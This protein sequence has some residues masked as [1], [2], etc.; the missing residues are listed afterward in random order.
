[1]IFITVSCGKK[2]FP[3]DNQFQMKSASDTRTSKPVILIM[4]DSLLPSAIQTGLEQDILPTFKFLME[5]GQYYNDFVSSFPTMSV[6]IDSTLLTGTYPDKHRV[7]GLLWYS[8]QDR[9]LINYGTTTKEIIRRGISPFLNQALIQLNGTHLS[10][11][12][13]T[14]YED[15][16]KQGLQSGSVNGIIHRGNTEHQLVFP[17]WLQSSASMPDAVTVKGPDFFTYG[18]FSNPL[19]GVIDLKDGMTQKMG[20]N[21]QFSAD[22][23]S[24]LIKSG[25]MPHFLMVY[26]PDLDQAL[27]HDGP[28]HMKKVVDADRQLNQIMQSY[29]SLD[30][31]LEKAVF[32]IMGDSGVSQVG[33]TK[34]KPIIDLPELLNAYRV[35]KPGESVTDQTDLVLA[36]NETMTYVYKTNPA[37]DLRNIIDQLNTD[38]RIDII[39]WQ[40]DGWIYV[41][42]SGTKQQMRYRPGGNTTDPYRQQWTLE[43][44]FTVLDLKWDQSG[45]T[46]QYGEY[47]DVLQRLY[48]ALNSHEGEYLVTTAKP[49]YEFTDITSHTHKGGGAHGSL[50]RIESLIPLFIAGTDHKPQNQRIVDLKSYM[51][52]LVTQPE[53][54]KVR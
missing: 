13:S 2:E 4:V 46:V 54:N 50:H 20:M 6:T 18:A 28:S 17:K 11:Q 10:P 7:P 25:Q 35:F 8:S 45:Q 15:L 42:K 36:A 43:N 27:H 1:M 34:D 24:Y 14:I 53:L 40:E 52:E 26:F 33:K 41:E 12:V 21:N 37:I 48:S 38:E 30:L 29:G 44:D 19:K 5:H 31:A 32:I 47:P 22:V 3:D 23:A 9:T 16:T 39:S 49:G 51:L